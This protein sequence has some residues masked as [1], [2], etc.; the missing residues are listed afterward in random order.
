[1]ADSIDI[2]LWDDNPSLV[3]LLGFDALAT[4]VMKALTS[5]HLDPVTVG[6]HG[7]WGSGKSTVLGL[8]GDALAKEDALVVVRTDPWEY[9][10]QA[11]VKG[12]LIAE[13]L[14]ALEETFGDDASLKEKTKALAR[15]I[16][17]SRVALTLGKGIVGIP[18]SPKDWVDAFTPK[19]K[20]DPESMSGFRDGFAEL[21][22]TLP[23]VKRVVVLVDDL[24][25]CM[26]NAVMAVLE[27]IKLFLAVP[28]MAFVLAADQDMVRDAIAAS[29]SSSN[30]GERFADRYL[31]KIVQ[32]P[33]Y[34]P[35]LAAHEA[36]AYAALLLARSECEDDSHF[37]ALV[38][39][40]RS[41]RAE[42]VSPLLANFGD[43]AWRP[44][45]ETLLL[46]GQLTEGLG[47]DRVS[48]PRQIKRFLNAFGV[49][50]HIAQARGLTVR[51]AVIAKLLLLEDRHRK[52]F[53]TLVGTAE[54]ERPALLLAWEEWASGKTE[55]RP[56]GISEQSR[57]WASSAP[58]LA[59]EALGPYITLAAT[60]AAL[61][62]AG[63]LSEELTALV[64]RMIGPSQADRENALQEI[65]NRTPTDQEQAVAALLAHTQRSDDVGKIVVALVGIAKANAAV[66]ES[67]ATGIRERCWKRLDLAEAY[68]LGSSG[69]PPLV[70]LARDLSTDEGIE[71]SVRQAARQALDGTA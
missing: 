30:R 27:A 52:D 46:A 3:D 38:A 12:A 59:A 20:Q 7:P 31:E 65:V 37:S 33:V 39:H 35:R 18:T 68:E 19:P 9:D 29:L 43:L 67:I 44:S 24:D 70:A 22:K 58:R 26:P 2:A 50:Q 4:P 28:K 5:Q 53:E 62:L 49:R 21:L 71:G 6:I 63:P 61:V 23:K 47:A 40:C 10:D 69:V 54:S 15:R 1:M 45:E 60:L 51:P 66:G 36:E 16:S 48:N 25:R 42:N 56:D 13:V 55:T 17:W 41:R 14:G 64:L 8:L 32:L 11:D 57:A 34:L